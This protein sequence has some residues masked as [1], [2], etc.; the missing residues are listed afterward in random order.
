MWFRLFHR[1]RRA[2]EVIALMEM[3]MVAF[4]YHERKPV[5]LPAELLNGLQ[6]HRKH[7]TESAE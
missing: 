7:I 5:S 1:L 2:K 6:E 3:G 4:S